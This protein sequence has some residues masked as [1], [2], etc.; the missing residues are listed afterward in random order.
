MINYLKARSSYH[1]ANGLQ[2]GKKGRKK[3]ERKLLQ[4]SM[5]NVM[6]AWP[7]VVLEKTQETV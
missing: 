5:K 1:M 7:R 2:G 4:L 6:V 3:A